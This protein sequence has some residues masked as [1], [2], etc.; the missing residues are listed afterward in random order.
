MGSCQITPPKADGV[1]NS[2]IGFNQH[3]LQLLPNWKADYEV[4][5]LWEGYT[6]TYI[7][8]KTTTEARARKVRGSVSQSKD[9]QKAIS[10][11]KEKL[12]CLVP[13]TPPTAITKLILK[14]LEVE[15]D[16]LVKV[17][18]FSHTTQRPE[19][20]RVKTQGLLYRVNN[21]E[22]RVIL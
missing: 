9:C 2:K 16:E 6:Y 1:S 20:S 22:R 13:S 15:V 5:L 11:R 14:V 7:M 8:I 10:K 17:W 21:H 4:L 19:I 18:S 12:E 3:F